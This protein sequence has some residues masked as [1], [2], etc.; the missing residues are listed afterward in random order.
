[1]TLR[2]AKV[3]PPD[4]PVVQGLG[5]AACEHWSSTSTDGIASSVHGSGLPLIVSFIALTSCP[6]MLPED[7]A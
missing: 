2:V 3:R 7:N 6:A 4:D 1:L 5:T